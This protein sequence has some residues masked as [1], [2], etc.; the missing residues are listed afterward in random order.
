MLVWR[1]ALAEPLGANCCLTQVVLYPGKVR[2]RW[3]ILL[4]SKLGVHGNQVR[5]RLGFAFG[6]LSFG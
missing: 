1:K 6:T 4:V 3:R 5:G 2:V